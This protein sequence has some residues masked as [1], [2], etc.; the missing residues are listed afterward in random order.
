VETPQPPQAA[1]GE[2]ADLVV[3][4]LEGAVEDLGGEGDEEDHPE[5][6]GR[7]DQGVDG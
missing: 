5:G 7:P 3:V 1:E 2:V 4:L 6:D